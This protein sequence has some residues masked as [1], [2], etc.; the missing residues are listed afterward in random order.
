MMNRSTFL[1]MMVGVTFACESLVRP[2]WLRIWLP[3]PGG[4]LRTNPVMMSLG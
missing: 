3:C 2:F 4:K 1:A